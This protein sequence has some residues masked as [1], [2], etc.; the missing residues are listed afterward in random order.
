MK[1]FDLFKRVLVPVETS[2]LPELGHKLK[3]LTERAKDEADREIA[4]KKRKYEERQQEQARRREQRFLRFL[5]AVKI[6]IIH[7]IRHDRVPQL[8]QF[9][10]ELVGY[11]SWPRTEHV[12]R[13]PTQ[14]YGSYRMEI[15]SFIEWAKQH[16]MTSYITLRY[17]R[18]YIGVK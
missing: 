1:L 16:G 17:E 7:D 3:F 12:G 4:E 6:S 2:E 15:E 9:P 14:S 11:A 10:G 13:V 8:V 5:E 18:W